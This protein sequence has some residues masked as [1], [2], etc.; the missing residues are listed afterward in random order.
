MYSAKIDGMTFYNPLAEDFEIMS[1]VLSQEQNKADGF[2]FTIY[3]DNSQ[4]DSM[5]KLKPTITVYDDDKLISRGRIIDSVQGW[6]NEKQITCEGELAF[7]NDSVVRPYDFTNGGIGVSDYLIFLVNQHNSQVAPERQF[8]VRT[9][10]VT[11]PNDSIV[12]ADSTYPNT[13]S[14]LNDKL[15]SLLGGYF[16]LEYS[17]ADKVTYID[18]LSDSTIKSTQAIEFG[19]NLLDISQEEKTDSLYTAVIPLGA[20]ITNDDGTQS[21]HRVDITSVTA[22]G[23]DYIQDDQAVAL[24]GFHAHSVTYD[25]IT[26]PANLMATA[27][28]DLQNEDYLSKT[29]TLT[30]ADLH[31]VDKTIGQFNILQYVTAKSTPHGIDSDFLVTKRSL[32]MI[33]P[34]NSKLVIGKILPTL[35]GSTASANKAVND[36]PNQ[37]ASQT[38][39]NNSIAQV[40]QN[41]MS[42]L[43]TSANEIIAKVSSEYVSTTDDGYQTAVANSATVTQTAKDVQL[44]FDQLKTVTDTAN[45]A[46]QGFSDLSKYITFNALGIV[47]G[48]EGKNNKVIITDKGIYFV[49]NPFTVTDTTT[50][51][52]CQQ[53]S[54]AYILDSTFYF[55]DGTILKYINIGDHQITDAGNGHTIIIYTGGSN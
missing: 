1:P 5:L 53:N 46:S 15:I 36:I 51:L 25:N 55:S 42:A 13:L 35:T 47:L 38:Q 52:D 34:D 12:R 19:V 7:F 11:D 33:H 26:L 3:P 10:T 6:K 31:L 20:Q 21:G 37:T 17:E 2:T 9:V 23:E 40:V 8:K 32:D 49:N 41:Y 54:T 44:A 16:N 29:V 14:V 50:D 48:E 39:V 28:S 24:Y 45:S 22:H 4:Y 43:T 30:A 18:Y 27:R